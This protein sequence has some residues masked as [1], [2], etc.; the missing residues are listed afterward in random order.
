M[1]AHRLGEY[2]DDVIAVLDAAGVKRSALVGYFV[3]ARIAYAVARKYPGRV[4]A[5][6]G[7]GSVGAPGDDNS[8]WAE[9]AAQVCRWDAGGYGGDG[10]RGA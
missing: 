2:V 10:G 5:I 3:G 4:S 9:T 6:A 8:D 7:I 1:S